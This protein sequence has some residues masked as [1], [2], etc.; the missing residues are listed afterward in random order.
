[1][2]M[3]KLA[4]LAGVSVS[5]ISKAFSGSKEI[6]EDKRKYIF[7]VAKEAGC[8]D[9]YC[10]NIRTEKVIAVICPEFNSRFYSEQLFFLEKEIKKHGAVMV[11]S[12]SNF[13]RD[14]GARLLSLYTEQLKVDGIIALYNINCYKKFSVPIVVLGE[15]E[16]FDS[17]TISDTQALNE[18]IRH[19]KENGHK[20]IAFIG[21][22]LTS[23]R[24]SDFEKAMLK[25]KLEINENYIVEDTGRFELAGY[26]AMSTLLTLENRPT[27]VICAY[28]NIAIGAMR[29][30]CEHGLRIPE[31]I[32][33]IGSDDI[34]EAPFLSVPL[35]SI[36]AYNED[37]CEILVDMLFDRINNPQKKHNK[38]IKVSKGLIKRESVGKSLK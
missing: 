7:E 1:M 4:K 11:C 16:N 36:T 10:K 5:T 3:D 24:K 26:N 8:Y 20:N 21:E 15:S 32:S 29:S 37:L 34:N 13:D 38:N 25:N 9:K 30:I 2:T 35:T 31:D 18:A 14:E 17:V 22:S 6:S 12:C 19:L 28:D 23:S 33:I 27:A